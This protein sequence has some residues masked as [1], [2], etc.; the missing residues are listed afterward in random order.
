MFSYEH[1]DKYLPVQFKTEMQRIVPYF[2]IMNLSVLL[3]QINKKK[4]QIVNYLQ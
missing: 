1:V 4:F 2:C 3:L